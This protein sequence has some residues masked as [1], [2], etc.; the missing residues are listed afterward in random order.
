MRKF[1][2]TLLKSASISAFNNLKLN[3]FKINPQ[4]ALL[5]A[6]LSGY[7]LWFAT[8]KVYNTD[9]LTV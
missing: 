6:S 1:A 9:F 2:Q 8:T 7:A 3:A 5:T 4:K